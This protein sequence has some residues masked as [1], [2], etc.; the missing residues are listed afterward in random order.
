MAGTVRHNL[1]PFGYYT[2][3]EIWRALELAHLKPVVE[4]LDDKLLHM[5]SEGGNNF[6]HGQRQLISLARVILKMKANTLKILVLDE[7][8]ASVDVETD[9]IIQQT[10]R[11]QFA[12]KTIITIAHRLDTVMDSDKILLLDHGEVKEFDTP[13][14]LLEKGGIFA[15]LCK[16]GDYDIS[17]NNDST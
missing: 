16:Q 12:D 11:S 13:K 9:R 17:S 2:D 3:D 7:A 5:V 15:E 8:T 4:Q 6:S 1:D 14:N 10:I